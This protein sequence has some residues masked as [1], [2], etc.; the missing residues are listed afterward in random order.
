MPRLF[1]QRTYDTMKRTAETAH[2]ILCKAI[3]R[4]LADPAY[5]EV[6]ELD[7]RLVDLILLPR[8]YDATLPFARVDT[9]LNEDDYSVKFCE[10]NGD[11][12]RA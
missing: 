11:A 5:R 2:R 3:E 1:N 12:P 7:P 8:G 10:F 9:F 4:Y 6:F